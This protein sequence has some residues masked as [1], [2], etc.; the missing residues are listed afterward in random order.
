MKIEINQEKR[1]VRDFRGIWIR[2]L[3]SLGLLSG[4]P[5]LDSRV[6]GEIF[7]NP[8]YIYL[9]SPDLPDEALEVLREYFGPHNVNIYD[10]N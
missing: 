1:R 7:E 2:T 3:N 9:D 8:P 4:N 5:W 10:E 6:I